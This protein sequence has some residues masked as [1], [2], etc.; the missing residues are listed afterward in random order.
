MGSVFCIKKYSCNLSNLNFFGNKKRSLKKNLLNL[1]DNESDQDIQ[2]QK[3]FSI[4]SNK[5]KF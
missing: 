3:V 5:E 4:N 2:Y 1:S